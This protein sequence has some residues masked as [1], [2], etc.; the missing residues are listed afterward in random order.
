M[1]PEYMF[2]QE[3]NPQRGGGMLTIVAVLGILLVLV[4]GSIYYKSKG[5][6]QFIGAERNKVLAQQMAEAGVEANIGDLGRRKTR[7]RS[8]LT[9]TATYVNKT[10]GTGKYSSTLTTVAVG[11]AADTVDLVSTGTVGKGSH[12]VRARLKLRKA[13]DTSTAVVASVKPETSTVITN[14]TVT[15]TDTIPP[16]TAA[17]MPGATTTAAYAACMSGGSGT[18]SICHLPAGNVAARMVLTIARGTIAP[19]HGGHTGD[20]VTTDGTCD[21]YMTKYNTVTTTKPDTAVTVVNKTYFDT[22][23]AIDTLVKVHILS[24]R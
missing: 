24:W 4:Q 15:K 23:L 18:C 13:M 7:V 2:A 17:S 19:V 9:D 3:S 22:T 16:P 21:L 8:G 14:K 20:Y 11:A 5:S 6:T 10:L 1:N 12:T